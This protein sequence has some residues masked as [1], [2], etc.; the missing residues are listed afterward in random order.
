MYRI[1]ALGESGRL[2]QLSSK[3]WVVGHGSAFHSVQEARLILAT[4]FVPALPTGEIIRDAYIA[5]VGLGGLIITTF[6]LQT[7][8]AESEG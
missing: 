6:A 2:Y 4:C 1:F 3:G 8:N 7:T 5:A